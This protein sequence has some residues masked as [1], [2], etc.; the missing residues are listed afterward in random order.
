M[1]PECITIVEHSFILNGYTKYSLEK[2]TML[3]IQ[4]VTNSNIFNSAM[5][6]YVKWYPGGL[7]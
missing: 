7:V 6:N 5:T 2:Y 1:L 3:M 4:G